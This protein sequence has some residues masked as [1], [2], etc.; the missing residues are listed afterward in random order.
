MRCC[1]GAFEYKHFCLSIS[2]NDEEF[3]ISLLFK[4]IQWNRR[5]TLLLHLFHCF[6]HRSVFKSQSAVNIIF[7]A[8][9]SYKLNNNIEKA[10]IIKYF[11][12][13]TKI[14][15][16]KI[17]IQRPEYKL[18]NQPINNKFVFFGVE[19]NFCARRGRIEI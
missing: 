19:T 18:Y 12:Q 17:Q 16:M 13:P 4:F 8:F 3:V 7:H 1:S 15:Q 9:K 14:I 5:E 10:V 2:V 6:V 11:G